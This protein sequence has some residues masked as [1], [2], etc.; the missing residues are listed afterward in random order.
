MNKWFSVVGAERA[1]PTH[2]SIQLL[3][4]GFEHSDKVSQW[5]TPTSPLG[6]PL[7]DTLQSVLDA[8]LRHSEKVEQG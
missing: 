1:N 2:L 3:L 4:D 6:H 8:E 7:F 5:D